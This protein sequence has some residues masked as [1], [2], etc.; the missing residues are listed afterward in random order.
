MREGEIEKERAIGR[1]G[2]R[3]RGGVSVR[4]ER[5]NDAVENKK[6]E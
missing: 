1:G 2:G 6:E 5:E 3:R 4:R